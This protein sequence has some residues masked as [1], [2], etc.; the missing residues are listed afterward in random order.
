MMPHDAVVGLYLRTA[1]L[2]DQRATDL[3]T[4]I[5]LRL[6]VKAPQL[7]HFQR[8]QSDRTAGTIGLLETL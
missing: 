1:F 3:P 6:R 2:H 8:A 4:E 7:R 5:S